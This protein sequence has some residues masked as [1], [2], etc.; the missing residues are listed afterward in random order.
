MIMQ[1]RI[2]SILKKHPMAIA[3]YLLYVLLWLRIIIV[4]IEFERSPGSMNHAERLMNGEGL[5]YAIFAALLISGAFAFAICINAVVRSKDQT[6]FYLW[7]IAAIILPVIMIWVY[8][9][10]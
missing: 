4:D 6:P 9:P 2:V 8:M 7:M 10:N 5:N 3:F 1:A